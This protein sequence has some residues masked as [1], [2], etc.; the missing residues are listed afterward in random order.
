[1]AAVEVLLG[2]MAASYNDIAR[3]SSV[4]Q[5]TVDTDRLLNR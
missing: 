2:V 1:M 4:I 3:R 5:I